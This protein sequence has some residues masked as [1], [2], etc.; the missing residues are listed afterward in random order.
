M[1]D[2]ARNPDTG[3]RRNTSRR[4]AVTPTL[5]ASEVGQYAF[6]QRAWWLG[7]V[8][9]YVSANQEILRA[10]D[11]AHTRHGR[12]VA[13][14]IRWRRTGLVLLAAGALLAI[15]LL[16]RWFGVAL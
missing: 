15:I 1:R 16:G 13:A 12:Q 14:A 10:G 7:S 2:A 4:D 11:R 5:R 8:C 3:P 9:G 6:C